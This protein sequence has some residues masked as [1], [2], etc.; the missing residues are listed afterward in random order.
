MADSE[1]KACK[2]MLQSAESDWVGATKRT[3]RLEHALRALLEET[4]MDEWHQPSE[5]VQ[6]LAEAALAEEPNAA[7]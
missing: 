4:M 6:G 1:H 2:A 5:Y 3:G 7:D